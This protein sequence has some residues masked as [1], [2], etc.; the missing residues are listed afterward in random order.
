MFLCKHQNISKEA[1]IFAI[2]K[3]TAIQSIPR[4]DTFLQKG[5]RKKLIDSLREKGVQDDKVLQAI[6]NVPRHFFLDPAFDQFSYEDKAFSIGAG[7]TI[8]HPYTVAI[9]SQL[10]EVKPFDKILEVGTGSAYQ[11]CVLAELG[12]TVYTIERQQELFKYNN[13]F[14][15][16]DKYHGRIKRFYG[17]GFKGLPEFAPFDKIIITA[18]APFVPQVLIDQL[19]NGGSMVAP[20]NTDDDITRQQMMR[21]TKTTSGFDQEMFGY[22]NFVPMLEGRQSK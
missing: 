7:Q 12:A 8:S 17:D 3:G 4:E 20:V 16:L 14:F 9:Q 5:K 10:L 22:F 19:K 2:M 13:K 1:F 21:Y 6:N 15:F 11:A 18:A